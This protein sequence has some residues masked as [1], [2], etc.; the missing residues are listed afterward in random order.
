[1]KQV[2]RYF[3]WLIVI[4]TAAS[5]FINLP[6]VSGLDIKP[7][8]KTISFDPAFI[9]RPLIGEKELDFRK[10][11]D[12]EGGTSLVLR[13]DMENIASSQKESA[14]ES[15]KLVIEK[16]VNLFGV[17]EPIV[18]TSIAGDEYRIIVELP[19]LT[20]INQVRSL[21][22]TTA[23]LEFWEQDASAS[24]QTASPS[25]QPSFIKTNLTGADIKETS[26]SFDTNTGKPQVQLRFTSEGTKKFAEITKRNI[27]KPVA[28][29]LDNQLI[30]SPTVNQ[31]IITGDAVITGS[32]TVDSAN[33]L[34]AQ[35]NAGALPVPLKILSSSIIEPTLGLSSLQK[36]LLAGILGFI[37][38]VI[39]MCVLYGRLGVVASIALILYTLFNLAIF[40]LSSITPYGITLTLSGIA[41]FILSIGMA[42]DANILIFERTKEELRLGKLKETAINLGFSRA[43][44]SIR[45]SNVATLITCF[46]LYQF[47][48]GIVKGFALVLA[49]GVL[50]SM[51]SAIAVTRTILKMVYK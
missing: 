22:G 19:G 2:P 40:K 18:Q 12:L 24:A 42:V 27:G 30:E 13:A 9:F 20:D 6:K 8:N 39:F 23:E 50:I 28:I 17:S 35:L 15:A 49:I 51:F 21:I 16:R 33:Q 37:I 46:V 25:A 31:A 47:G 44:T 45:D 29:V 4:L 48:T 10:G 5:V 41:G 11:L 36:S 38:I 7:L 3:F 26:V 1:M 14:L 32:F 34:S 43:W